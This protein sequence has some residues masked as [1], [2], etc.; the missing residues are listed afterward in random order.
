MS[1]SFRKWREMA[2]TE[3]PVVSDKYY[4]KVYE[5]IATDPQTGESILVQLTLQG[6]LDKCEGTNFEEPIRKCI[7]KCVYTSCKLEKEINK[8][9]NQYYEV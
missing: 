4:K 5:N 2:L 8:V 1:L 9:M 6:V 7:M 3:Y